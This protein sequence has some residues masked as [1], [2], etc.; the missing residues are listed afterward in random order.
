MAAI[1]DRLVKQ[2][3]G[4]GKTKKAD[5]AIAIS[6]L[7]KTGNL[8]KGTKQATKKGAK[9]GKMSPAERAKDRASK[10]SGDSSKDY[11]YNSKNNTA[12]KGNINKKV[13]ARK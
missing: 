7:Q 5:Y 3:M 4:N 8:K 2:L 10:K 13:K 9:R 1:L 6:S 12:V 11:K